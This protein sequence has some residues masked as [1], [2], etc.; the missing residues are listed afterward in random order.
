MMQ[1]SWIKDWDSTRDFFEAMINND[2]LELFKNRVMVEIIRYMWGVMKPFFIWFRF[3]PFVVL[4][5]VP[6]TV[7]TFIP[8]DIDDNFA[9]EVLQ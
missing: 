5:Y 9:L 7:F 3:V 2:D 1:V 8:Y 6:M 4:L